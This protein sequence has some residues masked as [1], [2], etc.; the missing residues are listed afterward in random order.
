[1]RLLLDTHVALWWLSAHP[2]LNAPAR[3]MI[4]GAEC[5]LSAASVWEVAIKFRLGKLP[6]APDAVLSAARQGGI[7]LLPVQ[8][9]HAVA[10][11]ALPAL[12]ADPFDRLLIAQARS[13]QLCLLTADAVVASY[14]ESI[15]LLE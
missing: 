15:R 9:E 10:T 12:H 1:M 3:E 5:W 14:G 7:H 13:D 2:R 11:V 8:A 6:V 4:A